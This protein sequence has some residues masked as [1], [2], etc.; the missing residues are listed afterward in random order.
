MRSLSARSGSAA[1]RIGSAPCTWKAR[2]GMARSL[3]LGE[4][5]RDLRPHLFAAREAVPAQAN[6]ADQ[7]V[8]LVD[9]DAVAVV[10]V[11]DA[12]DQQRLDV[13]LE[14]R[15]HR[16]GGL[17]EPPGIER[18]EGLGGAGGAGVE[19]RHAV[20]RAAAEEE[21]EPDGDAQRVP[22]CI[23][24][25]EVHQLFGP[26]RHPLPARARPLAEEHCA[27][28]AGAPQLA[29]AWVDQVRVPRLDRGGTELATLALFAPVRQL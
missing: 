10:R 2:S 22:V 21:S 11:A 23:A 18:D 6:D 28:V 16:V 27:G 29:L 13:G 12:V 7:P 26:S 1:K 14:L 24:E 4:E 9:R 25:P 15:Q 20:R 5:A 19:R 8:A 17:E 3:E